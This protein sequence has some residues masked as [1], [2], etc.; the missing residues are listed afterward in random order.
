[1]DNAGMHWTDADF[2]GLARAWVTTFVQT[3]GRTKCFTFYKR[4]TLPL[5]ETP[6]A[7]HDDHV[8]RPNL[9]GMPLMHNVWC[10]RG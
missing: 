2:T 10:T 1:M 3:N 4:L 9:S 8:D 7:P 5:T 6:S